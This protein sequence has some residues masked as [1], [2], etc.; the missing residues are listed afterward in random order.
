MKNLLLSFLFIRSISKG[1]AQVSSEEVNL[2]G[3]LKNFN[4]AVKVE[5]FSEFLNFLP[6]TNE[7]MIENY[8]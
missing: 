3:H 2:K 5:N 1:F 6:L 4:N 7:R 8:W